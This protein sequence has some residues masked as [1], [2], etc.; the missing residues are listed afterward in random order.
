MKIDKI[1]FDMDGVLADYDGG[2]RELCGFEPVDQRFETEEHEK[3]K[4]EK[5]RSIGHFYYKLKPIDGALELFRAL[6]EKYGNKVEILTGVPKPHRNIPEA[7]E[8]KQRWIAEY[9]GKEVKVNI[10]FKEDKKLFCKG[11]S[12]ILIDDLDRNINEWNT[13]GGTG[14]LFVNAED[15]MENIKRIEES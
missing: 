12:Y 8:D 14:I 5:V 13:N 9:F 2:L 11:K 1:Y 15:T 7:G 6:R 3:I 10:V 4:W